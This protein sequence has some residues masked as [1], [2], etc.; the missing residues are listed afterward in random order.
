M[1]SRMAACCLPPRAMTPRVICS[2]PP[3]REW[4]NWSLSSRMWEAA[5][6]SVIGSPVHCRRTLPGPDARASERLAWSRL[7]EQAGRGRAGE[8]PPAPDLL[9]SRRGQQSQLRRSPREA[10]LAGVVAPT[11]DQLIVLGPDHGRLPPP[12]PGPA[13]ASTTLLNVIASQLAGRVA[14]AVLS[15]TSSGTDVAPTG[16]ASAERASNTSLA[17]AGAKVRSEA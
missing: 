17:T 15:D 1:A 8:G 11:Q 6:I 16:P 13:L 3:A 2:R 7:R 9:G 12:S 5:T 10:R 4:R 14:E